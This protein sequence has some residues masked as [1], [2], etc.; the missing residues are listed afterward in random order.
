V[1]EVARGDT[2]AEAGV[3]IHLYNATLADE[4]VIVKQTKKL[5]GPVP[6]DPSIIARVEAIPDEQLLQSAPSTTAPDPLAARREEAQNAWSETGRRIVATLNER[7][8][9]SVS[10]LVLVILGAALG[11]IFRG[12][13][14]LTAFGISFVPSLVV[15]IAIVMGKQMAHN[16]TTYGIGLR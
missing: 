5:L 2:L 7:M 8:A 10:V 1:V 15:I 13:Q 12:A 3:R 16:A 9:F 6:I 11:I 4:D 14:V